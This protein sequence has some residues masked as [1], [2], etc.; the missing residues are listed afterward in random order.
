MPS[1]LLLSTKAHNLKSKRQP[2]IVGHQ[3]LVAVNVSSIHPIYR[4]ILRMH[5]E[6][7]RLGVIYVAYLVL[8][9]T[10]ELL[11]N[12]TDLYYELSRKA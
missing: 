8:Y 9:L 2:I 3:V 12:R 4:A 1:Q 7:C 11:C 10:R 5:G 6:H